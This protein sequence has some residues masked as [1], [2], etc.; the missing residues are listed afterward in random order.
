MSAPLTFK[1]DNIMEKDNY[2]TFRT[3]LG[4]KEEDLKKK[5]ANMENILDGEMKGDEV[6]AESYEDE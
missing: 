3:E 6:V 5:K 4:L 1:G 2:K